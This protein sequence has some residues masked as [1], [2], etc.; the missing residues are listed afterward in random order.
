MAEAIVRYNPE[1]S[2]CEVQI[3]SS[4]DETW[5]PLDAGEAGHVLVDEDEPADRY[6]VALSDDEGLEPGTV[7]RL[8]PLETEIEE[9][10]AIE[11][12]EEELEEETDNGNR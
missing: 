5:G 7:Y 8:E 2:L 9:D 10:V 3:G 1:R 4:D 12:P 11:E 6:Y